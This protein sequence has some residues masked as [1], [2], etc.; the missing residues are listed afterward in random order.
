MI[1]VIKKDGET[2]AVPSAT[3]AEVRGREVVCYDRRGVIIAR[4]PSDTV[5]LFGPHLP[6]LEQLARDE[7][8]DSAAD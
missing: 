6:S 4:F 7:S 1:Q 5:T 2:V 3:N 8:S